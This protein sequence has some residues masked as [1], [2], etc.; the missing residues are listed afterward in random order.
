MKTTKTGYMGAKPDFDGARRLYIYRYQETGVEKVVIGALMA[1]DQR[2]AAARLLVSDVGTPIRLKHDISV[3][4]LQ[5]LPGNLSIFHTPLKG[6]TYLL[7]FYLADDISDADAGALWRV[8][9][10][11]KM[12]AVIHKEGP[13]YVVA[14][15]VAP[16]WW[17][18]EFA[19]RER[20]E[21]FCT[22]NSLPWT[23][24]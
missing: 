20:A 6:E 8:L 11:G 19:S 3:D 16:G 5:D 18:G 22:E 15:Q 7:D 12:P 9:M 10:D 14:P 23:V 2:D 21:Q 1:Y 24:K 17:L 4:A 13:N